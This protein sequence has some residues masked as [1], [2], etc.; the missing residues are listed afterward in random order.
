[1][2]GDGYC[3]RELNNPECDYDGGDCCSSSRPDWFK[4]CGY[5]CDC[6]DPKDSPRPHSCTNEYFE[7]LAGN[8]ECD[9]ELNNPECR[10]DDGDCCNYKHKFYW[11]TNGYCNSQLNKPECGYDGG[12]CCGNQKPDWDRWCKR[13][14]GTLR[15]SCACLDP[16]PLCKSPS[17]IALSGNDECNSELNNPECGYDGG[18]CCDYWFY[19][20][21][22]GDGWCDAKLNNPQCGYDG[23]DCCSSSCKGDCECKDPKHQIP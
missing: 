20:E 21:W 18:D 10:Y 16:Y 5:A 7:E 14:D 2:F 6:L 13:S 15:K 4:H 19:P 11:A 9:E 23:G 8:N 3:D 22:F 12:D 1:M 17:V